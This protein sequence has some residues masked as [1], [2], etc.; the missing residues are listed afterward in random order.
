MLRKVLYLGFLIISIAGCYR[1]VEEG[2]TVYYDNPLWSADGGKI[3]FQLII[4]YHRVIVPLK[5]FA[6]EVSQYKSESY[7]MR[8][9]PDGE[10]VDTLGILYKE[11]EFNQSDTSFDIFLEDISPHGEILSTFRYASVGYEKYEIWIMDTCGKNRKQLLDWGKN[12]R[13]AFNYTK[14]IFNGDREH[15][16]IWMMDKKGDDVEK[17]CLG[18]LIS[19]SILNNEFLFINEKNQ[20]CVY[21]LE[22]GTIDTIIKKDDW[23]TFPTWNTR[24]EKILW[25]KVPEESYPG[26]MYDSLK[27]CIYSVKEES[28]ILEKIIKEKPLPTAHI[29]RLRWQ[30]YGRWIVFEDI[31]NIWRIRDDGEELM[32]ILPKEGR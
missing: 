32:E 25:L 10:F 17:V 11:K 7:L 14:V 26:E 4:S 6:K 12:P 23:A 20:I 28:L 9:N 29:W 5:P 3:Y 27:L 16:G 21:K 31:Y 24:G 19:Y 13:W 2:K 18:S 8:C 15:P 1:V 22:T 30:P